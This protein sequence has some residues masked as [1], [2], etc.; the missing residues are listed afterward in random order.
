M[1]EQF[2]R[3][4]SLKQQIRRLRRSK[5]PIKQLHLSPSGKPTDPQSTIWEKAF[6]M[7]LRLH[8]EAQ[9]IPPLDSQPDPGHS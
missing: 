3:S 9:V 8:L 6:L 2:E 4:L 5:P 7:Q 1:V